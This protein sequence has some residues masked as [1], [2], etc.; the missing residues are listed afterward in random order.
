MTYPL[1]KT[2]MDSWKISSFCVETHKVSTS[3]W[4][5]FH[6][7]QHKPYHQ[8][9]HSARSSWAAPERVWKRVRD[10][11]EVEQHTLRWQPEMEIPSPSQRTGSAR[12]TKVTVKWAY[13]WNLSRNKEKKISVSRV[14]SVLWRE[15]GPKRLPQTAWMRRIYSL[16]RFVMNS[17]RNCT[18][19]ALFLT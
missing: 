9:V 17:N 18:R 6:V 13:E 5:G 12:C 8:E 15:L 3:I 14:I 19:E 7:S 1:H 16:A 4:G 10:W 11:Q 2:K